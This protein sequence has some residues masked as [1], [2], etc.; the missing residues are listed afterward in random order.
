M[1]YPS[2]NSMFEDSEILSDKFSQLLDKWSAHPRV[3]DYRELDQFIRA[4]TTDKDWEKKGLR[5]KAEMFT[6]ENPLFE[7]A[8][9]LFNEY[10]TSGLKGAYYDFSDLMHSSVKNRWR[11]LVEG[12]HRSKKGSKAYDEW[13]KKDEFENEIW[14]DLPENSSEK[15]LILNHYEIVY[16]AILGKVFDPGI[17]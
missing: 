11:D 13:I 5:I 16:T 7:L 8:K 2:A 15:D 10:S 9:K 3:K 6:H 17:S 1:P 14:M 4:N 12:H